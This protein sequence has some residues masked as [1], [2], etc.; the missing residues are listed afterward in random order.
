M[1]TGRVVEE[2]I[3]T[4]LIISSVKE[5]NMVWEEEMN[6][7]Y[8]VKSGYNL[9]MR[10]IVR[11]DRHHERL[12]RGCLSTRV[13]LTQRYVEC[14]LSCH[15]CNVEVEDDIH[16]FFGCV[17]A[18]EC[19]SVAGLSQLLQNAAYQHGTVAD[20]VFGMCRNE[21]SATIGRVTSLF[22]C[23][24]H[25][26]NEKIWND[27]IPSPSQVGRM[28]FVVWNKW[29]TVHQLQR[30]NV[31][32]VEDPRPVR[33]KKSRVGCIKCNVDV[34]FVVGSGVTSMGLC[35]RDTNGQFVAGLT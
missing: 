28:T 20:R 22:W 12:C 4:L 35:F 1:F 8:S 19:R 5:D 30:H 23:I 10:C 27:N 6:E 11:S 32:P 24:W 26:R 33:W 15:V 7:C 3:A 31:V 16:V 29:F 18:R 25:N 2:I 9:A 14:E 21:D 17:A 34:A 13:R